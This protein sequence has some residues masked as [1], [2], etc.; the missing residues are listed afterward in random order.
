MKAILVQAKTN[1][2]AAERLQALVEARRTDVDANASSTSPG[3]TTEQKKAD[4]D[5]SFE[6]LTGGPQASDSAADFSPVD[7]AHDFINGA[8]FEGFTLSVA[9]RARDGSYRTELIGPDGLSFFDF[10]FG[11]SAEATGFSGLKP[12]W[13]AAESQQGNVEYITLSYNAVAAASTTVS[14]D[15]GTASASTVGARSSQIT[16]AIDFTT[17]TIQASKTDSLITSTA[18]TGQAAPSFSRLA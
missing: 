4:I 17:G 9:A 11:R 18:A 2:A 15:A 3:S 13:S 10:R 12:G 8:K 1:Q 16:F 6:R 7:P 5:K 14:S